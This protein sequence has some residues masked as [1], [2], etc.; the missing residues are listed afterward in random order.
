MTKVRILTE[1]GYYLHV[2]NLTLLPVVGQIIKDIT[3]WK[4]TRVEWLLPDNT[5]SYSDEI[6]VEI[7][8]KQM[9]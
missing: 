1:D 6:V 3:N 7:H 9:F 2:G 5:D 4:V 8:T